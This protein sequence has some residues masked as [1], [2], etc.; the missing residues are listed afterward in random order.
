MPV[1]VP[2]PRIARKDPERVDDMSVIGGTNSSDRLVGTAQSEQIFAE[3]GADVV[4]AGAGDDVVFGGGGDD[5]LLGEAGNDTIFG[6]SNSTGT[7]D[8]DRFRIAES[9]TA[10][11]TFQGESAGY[12]N[13]L[14]MYRIAEDGTIHDVEILFANA[15]LR[16]SGGNLIAG[17]SSVQVDLEAGDTI[18]FFVVPDG[19]S[20]SGAPAMFNNTNGDFHFVDASGAPGNVN[21]G[22]LTLVHTSANGTQTAVRSAHGNTVYHSAS[23]SLNGDGIDHVVGSVDVASGTVTL[24]F[25]DLWRGGDRDFDDSVFTV[26]IG[27]TNAALLPRESSGASTSTDND[28]IVG[29]EGDDRLFGMSGDDVVR[30]GAGNDHLWGNSGN[31]LLAGGAGDDTLAGG[32]GDDVVKGGAGNDSLVG[33]SGND[34]IQGG[35]GDD[36]IEGNSGDDLIV[37]GAGHDTVDAGSGDDV[38][39]A[40]A[41]NDYYNGRDGFDTLDYSGAGRGITLDLSK[42]T[43]VGMGRDEVWGVERVI[44]SAFDDSMR[45]D[46]RDNVLVGGAGNDTLRGLGG[47][48][49]LTGGEGS[50]TFVWLAKDV[51]DPL[52]GEHLGVDV[53]TDFSADD[54]LDLHELLKGQSYDA[55]DQV[56]RITEGDG[57]ATVAVKF[58]DAFVDVVTVQGATADDLLADGVILA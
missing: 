39:V 19:Y 35:G 6:A 18:G 52:S 42:H 28:T 49:T 24:G 50:D 33:N 10:T 38:M 16:N 14:G 1:F 55:L 32:S 30:G 29:G 54:T 48:D 27:V 56:V 13:V 26:D 40:S 2:A 58:G 57:G 21:G 17:Q 3:S 7:V 9:T 34:A 47:A 31:D 44:G 11:V 53:I 25:E 15:S 36:V 4:R 45:G 41:G 43:V 12:R 51:V 46:K 37:D 22:P 20:Q 8:L 5:R 23:S